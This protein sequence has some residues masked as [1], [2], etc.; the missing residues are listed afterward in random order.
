MMNLFFQPFIPNVK[1]ER[2]FVG[3]TD[4][5]IIS[6]IESFGIDVVLANE[7]I[8]LDKPVSNH[9]DMNMLRLN[10]NFYAADN[11]QLM[12]FDQY[13]RHAVLETAVNSP[14]PD[15]CAL[16]VAIVGDIFFSNPG[17]IDISVF[18][19]L[20]KTGYKNIDVKQGYSKCSTCIVDE[21]SIITDDSSIDKAARI[22]GMDSLLIEK[23]DI[24]LSGYDY[25][26]IGGASSLIDYHELIFFGDITKHRSFE[27]IDCFLKT[28]HCNYSYI[29]DFPLTDI[30]G[31][32]II[33]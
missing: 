19:H 24:Y 8:K 27:K 12:L 13:P 3:K 9:V 20:I 32:V 22:N 1:V 17:S 33:D 30:G 18:N 26:F 11:S 25:G 23:G 31:I 16:N 15:D 21:R 7:N 4:E 10:K 29:K 14:Y 28:K 6:F 2:V 5:K